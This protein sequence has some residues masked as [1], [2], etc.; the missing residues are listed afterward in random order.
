MI[1]THEF[2]TDDKLREI[3][4]DSF[5]SFPCFCKYSRLGDNPGD[6]AGWH[7][8]PAFEIN[9]CLEGSFRFRTANTDIQVRKGDAVFINSNTLHQMEPAVSG[10]MSE[11][12]TLFFDGEFLSG[13]YGTLFH[14]KY[15]MPVL[16]CQR[17]HSF[18]LSAS[19][20][21][22]IRMLYS[23]LDIVELFRDEPYGYEL[24]VR[25]KLGQF[26]LMLLE[27]T[28]DIRSRSGRAKMLDHARVKEMIGFLEEHYNEKLTL[29]DIASS[30]GLGERECSRCFSRSIGIPPIEYLNRYRIR[31][32]ARLIVQ[33]T[34]P[35]GHI[36]DQCGFSSDSYFGKMF[37]E[38]I[39]CSPREYRKRKGTT[40]QEK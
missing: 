14:E 19:N 27:E 22:G 38:Q 40:L 11:Y 2:R 26:W 24:D 37:R 10:T 9:Y 21:V 5:E 28:K 34:D 15:L 39:G 18:L 16:S 36:A 12:Y 33:S 3:L 20:T 31:Q 1:T 25:T 4:P 13:R 7:W 35:I 6:W 29:N 23:L 30:V 8:H 17:F 32:S